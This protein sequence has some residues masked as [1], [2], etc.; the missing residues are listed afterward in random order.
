MSWD[1]SLAH[2]HSGQREAT[3]GSCSIVPGAHVPNGTCVSDGRCSQ[4]LFPTIFLKLSSSVWEELF[5]NDICHCVGVLES[6]Q[7]FCVSFHGPFIYPSIFPP[8]GPMPT[9]QVMLHPRGLHPIAAAR[10]A[11]ICEVRVM[12]FVV[13]RM[14]FNE[15][16]M[17]EMC[18]CCILNAFQRI[19]N[20]RDAFVRCV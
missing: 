6:Q 14:H 1:T 13:F 4:F 10:A 20:V 18:F 15:I 17:C 7:V 8:S 16:E 9:V 11:C 2:A 12:C 19:R 3:P 5:G